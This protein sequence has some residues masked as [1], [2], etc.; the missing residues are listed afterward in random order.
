MCEYICGGTLFV[1]FR[2]AM[3]IYRIFGDFCLIHPSDGEENFFA[4]YF[5]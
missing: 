3:M 5:K 1:C 2:G 4:L